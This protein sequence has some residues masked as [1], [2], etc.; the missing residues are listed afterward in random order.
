MTLIKTSILTAISTIIRVVTRFIINKLISVYIGPSGLA[1]IGQLINFNSVVMPFASGAINQGVVK[2]TAEY[3]E[4]FEKKSKLFSTA[5]IITLTSSVITGIIISVFS[6]YFSEV[7]LKSSDYSSVFIVFGFTIIFFALNTLLMAILN[8]QKEI[9][10]FILVNIISSFFSLIFTSGLI[11]LLGLV[12]ALYA[13]VVN[14]SVIFFITLTFVVKSSWFKLGYFKQGMDKKCLKLLLKY[15]AMAIVSALT[16]PIALIV[17]RNYIGESLSWDAA[18]YWEGIWQI[19]AMYLMVVT[20]SLSVYYLPRLSEI[21]DKNE[22]KREIISGYKIILPIVSIMAL[23]IYSLKE[24]IIL[25]AFTESFTPMLEL[26]KWQLIGDI[27]KIAAWLL[28]YLMLAK[29]MTRL[30]IYT[31]IIFTTSFVV[32]SIV[33]V[34]NF[35]LV[36]VTYG[37]CLN[38]VL[39]LITMIIVFRKRFA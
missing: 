18:G 6:S 39:Y 4:D 19:S 10:K 15:S 2:Y 8:G 24:Y 1:I 17:I 37:F 26:F 28:A 33:F 32:L 9:K 20:T 16:T 5:I 23:T 25:I 22:L 29:A 30:F 3:K 12:G 38:Y 31:E 36:G 11:V 13:L 35:G 14:Q 21:H 34:K 7:I 27:F